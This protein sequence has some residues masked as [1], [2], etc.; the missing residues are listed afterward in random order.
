M[1]IDDIYNRLNLGLVYSTLNY[2][3]Y[4]LYLCVIIH[5]VIYCMAN[6]II[7]L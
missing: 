4:L 1:Y 5:I 3:I 2:C 7:L 6:V